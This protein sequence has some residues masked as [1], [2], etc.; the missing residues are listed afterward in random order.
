MHHQSSMEVAAMEELSKRLKYIERGGRVQR[1]HMVPTLH[2]QNV[3][4]HSFGVAWWCWLLSHDNKPSANLLMSAMA[5]D[6]PE[7]RTGD[8]PAPT[9]R[10]LK[11]AAQL[12]DLEAQFDQEAGLPVFELTENEVRILKLSDCL[13][14]LQHCV[15]ERKL[16]NRTEELAEMFGNVWDYTSEVTETLLDVKAVEL[17]TDQWREVR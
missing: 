9:K 3:A 5:H 7:G 16:G 2:S 1:M 14:L 8:I 13:E 12:A 15:R 10:M 17:L 6:L 11:C 4:A